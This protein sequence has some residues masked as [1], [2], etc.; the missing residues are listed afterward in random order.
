MKNFK[1]LFVFNLVPV[2]HDKHTA[3]LI[4]VQTM[5]HEY[6]KTISMSQVQK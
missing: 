4:L 5:L 3:G 6:I 1:N 2:S